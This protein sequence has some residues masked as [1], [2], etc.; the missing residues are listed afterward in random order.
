LSQAIRC[1]K[2]QQKTVEVCCAADFPTC[3]GSN[4][5]EMGLGVASTMVVSNVMRS[6][7]LWVC[8]NRDQKETTSSHYS[9]QFPE[10]YLVIDVFDHV[11]R[12]HKIETLVGK[13][14]RFHRPFHD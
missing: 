8:W 14:H 9:A 12:R 5:D 2:R 13:R 3:P 6:P 4:A 10:R 1:G 7:E 11:K